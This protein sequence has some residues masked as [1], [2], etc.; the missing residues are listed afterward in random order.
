MSLPISDIARIVIGLGTAIR[1]G[2][3]GPGASGKSTLAAGLVEAL[4]DAVLVE[5]DD[6][7][8]L[9]LD[10]NRSEVE[11]AGLFDLQRLGSQVL[12]PH[13]Q[14]REHQYQ[15]Y[16]W[17]TGSLGDWATGASGAPLIVEGVYSTHQ[18]LRDFYDLR[19]WVTA[20]RAVRLARGIERDGEEARSKW[21]DVWM[22]AED[23]YVAEQAPQDHAH[24]VLDGSGA[25]I[26]QAGEAMFA[27]VGGTHF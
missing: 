13:S 5:G 10:S 21:V 24:L 11:I 15:R 18:M 9:E 26:D 17:E 7:Y 6:F 19:I 20:P 14:G 16:D 12:I 4:S 2:I 8:R 1:V 22:P 23:R 27:V 3:D 25:S